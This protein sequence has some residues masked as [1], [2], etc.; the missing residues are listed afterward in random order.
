MFILHNFFTN[1]LTNQL[2][3]KINHLFNKYGKESRLLDYLG[4]TPAYTSESCLQES[5][6]FLAI[7]RLFNFF[8]TPLANAGNFLRQQAS[9]SR[10]GNI[11]LPA[12]LTESRAWKILSGIRVESALWLFISYPIIDFTLRKIPQLSFLSSGWDEILLLAI[13]IAWPFQMALRGKI[14]YRY[15]SLDI[16]ILVYIG[17][18]LF[19]FFMRSWNISL[20][21][22]GMRI[23]LEY[24]IWFFVGSNLLLSR[25]QFNAL[26]KG[27]VAVAIIVAAVGVFQ[28]I[29]G[30]ETPEEWV[31][32]AEAAIQTR[33]FSIVV[34]PN[35]LGSLLIPFMMITA[36]QLLTTNKRLERWLYLGAL[37]IQAACMVFTYSRGAWLAFALSAVVFCF[38]YN[39]RLL[40]LAAAAAFAAVK[41]VPGIGSRFSYLFSSAYIS[42]SQRGGR[43]ALWQS[44]IDKF[45]YD[46]VF[47]SGFGTFGGAV[48]ARRVPGGYYVDNF[49]LKTLAESGIIGLAALIWLLFSLFRSGYS[50]C[51]KIKDSN[52]YIMGAA[53]FSGLLGIAAHN[54]VEN[55]FEVPMMTS[56]FWLLAGMLLALPAISNAEDKSR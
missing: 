8:I 27:I 47:G 37:A 55:I 48:A 20:A 25:R 10:L 19:L 36:G 49:Y 7:T 38:L 31:D 3:K 13:I 9:W 12:T 5:V 22:E 54:A 53:I 24:L 15:T 43:L 18:T 45:K 17:L 41:F 29:I 52:L 28:Q 35:V 1:S 34:S 16:P 2:I 39:P 14:Y 42:S 32:K 44:A 26:M 23:Y 6:F 46:P 50:A 40:I 4:N 56:Y 33:V 30:I 51:K 21:V 11:S